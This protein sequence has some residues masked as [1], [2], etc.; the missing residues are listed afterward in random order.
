MEPSFSGKVITGIAEKAKAH[1]VPVIAVVGKNKNSIEQLNNVGIWKAY[2][3]SLG[4]N[5]FEEIKKHCEND[6]RLTM[7]RI[8]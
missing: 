4:R 5:D 1:D 2:E 7:N 8:C 6:L 3:T